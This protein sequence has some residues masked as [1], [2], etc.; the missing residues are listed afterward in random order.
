MSKKKQKK[1][2]KSYEQ[3]PSGVYNEKP[4]KT[5]KDKMSIFPEHHMYKCINR[6]Y[7]EEELPTKLYSK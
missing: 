3:T 6:G 7:E 2:K 5:C 1:E 4:C